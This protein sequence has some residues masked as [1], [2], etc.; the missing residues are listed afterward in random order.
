MVSADEQAY[1]NGL[2][3]TSGSGTTLALESTMA[4]FAG[5]PIAFRLY[6][7]ATGVP[8]SRTEDLRADAGWALLPSDTTR[9]DCQL[10]PKM[11]PVERVSYLKTKFRRLHP[12]SCHAHGGF[13]AVYFGG[14][15]VPG[16]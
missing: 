16:R 9:A 4:D 7:L 10:I 6:K 13:A 12:D 14:R 8:P 5:G 11:A 15:L 2:L 3:A 1:V